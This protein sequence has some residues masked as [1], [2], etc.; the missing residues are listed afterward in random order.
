VYHLGRIAETTGDAGA[1]AGRGEGHVRKTLFGRACGSPHQEAVIAELAAGGSVAEHLHAFEE[2]FYVLEGELVLEVAGV[3]EEL[4]ADDYVFIDR[5]VAHSL[6][7]ESGNR[8]RWFEV[9]APQPGAPLDDTFFVEGEAPVAPTETPYRRDHFDVAALPAPSASIGLSGFGGANVGHA[10][11]KILVGPD[12]GASQFNLMVVQYAPGGYIKEHD[13]AFEEGFFFLEGEVDA[14]LEGK[15]YTLQAGD[16]CWSSVGSMHALL[17]R[18]DGI[19]RWLET[20]VPQPPSRYQARFVGDWERFV[21]GEPGSD[22]GSTESPKSEGP[23]RP[24][25][26]RK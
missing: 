24:A 9:S 4:G 22:V 3:R 20:Q 16:Y 25:R 19:V 18:S 17:N 11:L 2:A 14:E 7:N 21:A 13:H 10:S 15:T 26:K 5:G 8:C 23:A 12:T 6:A 1:Y